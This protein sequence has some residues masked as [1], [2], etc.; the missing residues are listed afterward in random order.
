MSSKLGRSLASWPVRHPWAFGAGCLGTLAVMTAVVCAIVATNGTYP[1]GVDTLYHVYKGDALYRSIQQGNWWPLYDPLWYNGTQLM[2][3]WA[4]LPVYVFAGCEA[5]AGGDALHAFVVFCGVVFLIGAVSW[6][7]VGMKVKRPWLGLIIG[8]LWLLLPNNLVALFSEGN[9]PRCLSLALLPLLV[10]FANRYLESGSWKQLVPVTV[11]FA[12]MALCHA[13]F[14]AMIAIAM[15]V[16]LVCYGLVCRTWKRGLAVIM[17]ALLGFALVGLWLVPALI[18]DTLLPSDAPDMADYFQSLWVTLNPFERLTSGNNASYFGCAAAA[19][20]VFGFLFAKR[21]S[22][23]GFLAA[24]LLVLCT[25]ELALPA[26]SKLPGSDAFWMLCYVSIALAF[27]LFSFLSWRTLKT[28][29]VVLVCVLLVADSTPSWT[30]AWGNQSGSDPQQRLE[31]TE[32]RMLVDQAKDVTTQRLAL[33]DGSRFNSESTY[34]ATGLHD[35][36]AISEGAVQ[37]PCVTASNYTLLDEALAQGQ[38]DYLFDRSLEL[39]NDSVLVLTS[40]AS[41]NDDSIGAHLDSSAARLGYHMVAQNGEYRLYHRDTPATFGVKSTYRAIAIGS[42]ASTVALQFPAFEEGSSQNLN[43][44]TFDQ[45]KRYDVVYLG[46]FT[47]NDRTAA[48]DLVNRLADEGVRVVIAADGIPTD[49]HTGQHTFLGLDCEDITF[50]NGFPEL[51]TDEGAL[52]TTLFPNG[53]QQWSTVY[54]NGIAHPSATIQEGDRTLPVCGT[55]DNPNIAVIGLNLTYYESLTHDANVQTLLAGILNVD[56]DELPQRD[57]VPLD[58]TYGADGRTITVQS[59]ENNV[60]TTLSYQDIFTSDSTLTRENNLL[61]VN[62]GTTV[63]QLRYPYLWQGAAVS[64][65]GLLASIAFFAIM[66]KRGHDKGTGHVPR[67][68]SP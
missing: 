58:V 27:M 16:Y 61:Y 11:L 9:L 29:L 64:T 17:A 68:A 2:R 48:E 62:S 47:F 22:M 67:P 20:C 38:F 13:G 54:V 32:Q 50:S 6:T 8:V 21:R 57:V 19:L 56:P 12:L 34:A 51:Q 3:Y 66:R 5:L 53:H 33:V 52:V 43:D 49:E 14:A 37:Q 35:P 15:A 1:E 28:P 46:G 60:N 63:I 24:A 10:L 40:L 31:Q 42:S 65:A 44:Y 7:Y 36:I 23:P 59:P 45:L 30:L 26:L 18:G 41:V 4:P 39:G 55:L 25:S